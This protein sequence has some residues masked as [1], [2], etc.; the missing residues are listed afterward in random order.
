MR[1]IEIA[2]EYLCRENL[3]VVI[4]RNGEII[5]KSSEKGI[6][7]LYTLAIE[8]NI[9]LKGSSLADKVIGRGAA[10][11]CKYFDVEEVYGLLISEAAEKV[12]NEAD[13]KYSYNQTCPYIKNRDNTGLCPIERMSLE[14]DDVNVLLERIGQFLGLKK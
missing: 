12:L 8:K 11:I 5:F 13:I 6:K 14:T 10:M 2:K 4:V 7:P 9:D 3:S 1:D